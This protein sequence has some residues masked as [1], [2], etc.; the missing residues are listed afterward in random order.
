MWDDFEQPERH[1]R[2]DSHIRC[3]PGSLACPPKLLYLHY[4]SILLDDPRARDATEPSPQI[5][6][7][8]YSLRHR[9]A[10]GDEETR[11]FFQRRTYEY[12]APSLPQ[13]DF[14]RDRRRSIQA[15]CA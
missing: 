15:G 8:R 11:L 10:G 2:L 14:K 9:L 1:G 3:P 13:T 5:G 7:L 12:E 6:Y 4:L